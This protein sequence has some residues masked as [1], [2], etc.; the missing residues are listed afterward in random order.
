MD[1]PELKR[2]IRKLK[3]FEKTV[4]EKSKIENNTLVWDKFFDQNDDPNSNALYNIT[5]LSSLS[6]DEYKSIVDDFI[7]RVY[8][9]IY[10]CNGIINETIYS[11]QLLALL[12]LSPVADEKDVKKR[13]RELAKKY[14]PDTGGD[15]EKF[16]ELMNIYRELNG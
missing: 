11:P 3:Q 1:I 5:M 2:K 9:E 15:H 16:I 4:R 10:I 7:A 6:K 12:D 14:H 13:F 8:Y